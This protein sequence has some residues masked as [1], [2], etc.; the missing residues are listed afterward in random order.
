MLVKG[1]TSKVSLQISS[2]L[3]ETSRLQRVV[4]M[5]VECHWVSDTRVGR[6]ACAYMVYFNTEH[7]VFK[8]FTSG[9]FL[10]SKFKS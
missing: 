6:E 9:P 4:R 2:V 7:P 5:M 1:C 8:A 3:V 10:R